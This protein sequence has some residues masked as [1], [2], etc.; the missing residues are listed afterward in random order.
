MWEGE[1]VQTGQ[2]VVWVARARQGRSFNVGCSLVHTS[3]VG[4]V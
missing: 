2:E 1:R 3:L 4:H